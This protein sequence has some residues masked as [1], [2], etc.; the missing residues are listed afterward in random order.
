M[1][2]LVWTEEAVEDLEAIRDYVSRDSFAILEAR[3]RAQHRKRRT[4]AAYPESSRVVPELGRKELR[5]VV[6]SYR[7]VYRL[8]EDAVPNSD[9]FPSLA[10]FPRF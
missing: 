3:G 10:P 9:D 4:G 8:H 7:V 1:T 5:E 2:R 6:G